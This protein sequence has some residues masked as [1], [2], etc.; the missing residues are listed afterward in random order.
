ML[1]LRLAEVAVVALL[2]VQVRVSRT[3]AIISPP[4]RAGRA[5]ARKDEWLK[6][7]LVLILPNDDGYRCR[8]N[9][10]DLS[11]DNSDELYWRNVVAQVQS[12]P[13][14]VHAVTQR[15]IGWHTQVFKGANDIAS[16]NGR[17]R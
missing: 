10:P 1:S 16:L 17:P 7:A 14:N 2:L 4:V 3:V 5:G 6:L 15:L 9:H 12:L 11:H 13:G 8:R